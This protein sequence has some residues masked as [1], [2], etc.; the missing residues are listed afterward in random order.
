M[1][2]LVSSTAVLAGLTITRFALLRIGIDIL[3][4]PELKVPM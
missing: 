4:A 2:G 1:P 3:A